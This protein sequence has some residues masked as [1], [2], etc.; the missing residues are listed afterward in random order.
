MLV[1]HTVG[2]FLSYSLCVPYRPPPQILLQLIKFNL[3]LL[4]IKEI[5]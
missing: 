2:F 4:Q 5:M 3:F 1:V